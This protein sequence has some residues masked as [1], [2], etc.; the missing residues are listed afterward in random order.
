M[1]A[2]TDLPSVPPAMADIALLD[3]RACA[4]HGALSVSWWHAKVATGEA[5][6][7]VVR[8]PRCTRWRAVD[9]RNFWVAFAEQALSDP[10]AGELLAGR[11]RKASARAREPAAVAKAKATRARNIAARTAG[12]EV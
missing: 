6:Q 5:P 4:A 12:G 2:K 1:T 10:Q 11:A 7:P 3:A 9:V 8:M